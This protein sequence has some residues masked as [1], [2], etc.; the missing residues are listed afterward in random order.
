MIG[1]KLD[2]SKFFF[3]SKDKQRIFAGVDKAQ[4]RNLNK[5]GGFI[6][7]VARRSMRRRKKASQPGQPP[8]ART[9]SPS[10][11]LGPLLKERL[12][13]QFDPSTKTVVV[14]P[15]KLNTI[16]YDGATQMRGTIPQTLEFG[17]SM[18]QMQYLD[19]RDGKWRKYD[20]RYRARG[21][22]Q[23]VYGRGV[24]KTIKLRRKQINIAARPYMAP[25]YKQSEPRLAG[26]WKDTV[27]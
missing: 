19:E 1:I 10:H 17:G 7:T 15:Q 5:S 27:K 12:F 25:A 4:A 22:S 11:P 14:G 9:Q 18:S 6:R 13:Y 23:K 16:A 24:M 26:V 8:S 21:F 2:K 3:E 20:A